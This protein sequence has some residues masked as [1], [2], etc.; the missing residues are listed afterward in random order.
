MTF[1]SRN[2]TKPVTIRVP[3]EML[4]EY[5]KIADD[6]GIA[7][8]KALADACVSW[9]ETAK[10]MDAQQE[11]KKSIDANLPADTVNVGGRQ[12]H[13]TDPFSYKPHTFLDQEK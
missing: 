12:V 4:E 10:S 13:L 7:T 1:L 11:T 9:W 3:I 6:T 2:K 5:K 8:S